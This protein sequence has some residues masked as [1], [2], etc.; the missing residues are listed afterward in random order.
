MRKRIFLAGLLAVVLVLAT[1]PA[2]LAAYEGSSPNP[3]SGPTGTAVTWTAGGFTQGETVT[4]RFC[5]QQTVVGTDVADG[6]GNAHAAFDI[7][8]TA[9]A[10]TCTLTGTGG[11]SGRVVT[12]AFTVTTT[13]IAYTGAQIMFWVMAGLGLIALGAGLL[14]KRRTVRA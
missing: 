13:N 8:A 10:G 9:P 7:P 1:A 12:T 11:T 3:S 2:V 5:S 4:F 14:M 6:S